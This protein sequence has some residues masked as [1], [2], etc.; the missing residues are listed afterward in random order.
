VLLHAACYASETADFRGL[1]RPAV[2]YDA[3]QRLRGLD[4]RIPMSR[5][6]KT[7]DGARRA[8]RVRSRRCRDE[9][10]GPFALRQSAARTAA[11]ELSV[12]ASPG[13]PP[14]Q[15]QEEAS[16]FGKRLKLLTVF[17]FPIHLDLSWFIIAL[18]ITWSLASGAFPQFYPDLSTAT[19]WWMGA[20]GAIGLFVCVLLHELGH[21]LVARRVGVPMKGITLFIFG[22]VAEM[23]DEPKRPGDEFY[24][25]IGGPVVTAV[26]IGLFF[27]LAF[28]PFPQAVA[29]VVNYLL[30]INGVLL[31]FNAIPAFPLD[32]G[33]VLRAGLWHYKGSL[34]WATRVS[35]RIGAGF[36]M[37][38]IVFA[39]LQLFTGNFVGAMWWFLIGMFLRGAAGMGYQQVLVRQ[40]LEGEP[41][42]RFMT[43]GPVS[44]SASLRLSDLVEEY[45]YKHHFKMFP[46]TED[47]ELVGCVTTRQIKEVPRDQWD[48]R[49]AGQIAHP[50]SDTN[51][52]HPDDDAMKTLMWMRRNDISRALVVEDGRL[53]GVLSLKDLMAFISL[54][55][56]LE[57]EEEPVVPVEAGP[58]PRRRPALGDKAK[59]RMA[60]EY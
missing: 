28:V 56:E 6:V 41:V 39:V 27:A 25:A 55:L 50:C 52:V 42:R 17:G 53:V 10:A 46:V 38:L 29:G 14:T 7:R 4:Y 44:V 47:G 31:G 48:E 45:V 30:I 54:K 23:T 51:S 21:A 36:G 58:E 37:L 2:R 24:V 3:F 11:K 43:E 32:G 8:E 33:R 9:D 60:R 15:P 57:D 40:A 1:E 16:I 34:R 22:G 20:A 12:P 35:S 13:A 19:H 26:L 5:I 59:G 49:T 18:L